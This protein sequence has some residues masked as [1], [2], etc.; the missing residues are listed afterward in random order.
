[1]IGWFADTCAHHHCVPDAR[2][3]A[4][5][6]PHQRGGEEYAGTCKRGAC[7]YEQPSRAF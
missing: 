1:M 6:G 5:G 3:R 4:H 2:V 7:A